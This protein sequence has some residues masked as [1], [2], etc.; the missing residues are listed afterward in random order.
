MASITAAIS[1]RAD[2]G[3]SGQDYARALAAPQQQPHHQAAQ[4]ARP[5]RPRETAP[6]APAGYPQPGPAGRAP[7]ALCALRFR[8]HQ[9]W[10]R[11]R[12]CLLS[13]G[14]GDLRAGAAAQQVADGIRGNRLPGGQLAMDDQAYPPLFI[15]VASLCRTARQSFR[16]LA[17]ARSR[18]AG[19]QNYMICAQF[20]HVLGHRRTVQIRQHRSLLREGGSSQEITVSAALPCERLLTAAVASP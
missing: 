1:A 3:A 17:I 12:R 5:A 2:A 6:T 7:R 13:R 19:I 4:S 20:L 18:L 14:D 10:Q 9:R 15:H 11:T 8:R 16:Y